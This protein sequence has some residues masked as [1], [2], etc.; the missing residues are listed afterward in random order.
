MSLLFLRTSSFKLF[1]IVQIYFSELL[2]SVLSLFITVQATMSHVTLIEV[3]NISSILSTHIIRAIQ[4]SGTQALFKT[5][6][7]II[8]QTQG[9]DGV[10]IE[11]HTAVI[12]T[13]A[14]WIKE[15]WISKTW[16]RNMEDVLLL[17]IQV[18]GQIIIQTN[19]H[20]IIQIN[21]FTHNFWDC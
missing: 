13:I 11:D 19:N 20:N 16:V 8:I 14:I 2:S 1:F 3:R 15:R 4:L 21:T 5:I 10:Q 12:I 6:D 17:T 7:S 9:V 18:S